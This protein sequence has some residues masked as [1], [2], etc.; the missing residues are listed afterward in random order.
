MSGET[1]NNIIGY[2][3]NPK[4]RHLS[5]GGSSGGEG[6]LIGL[7][8]SPVGFGSD[9]GGPIRVPAG[10]DGIFGIRPSNGRL[11]YRG[12]PISMDGQESIPCVIG[13]MAS[14][15]RS[16]TAIFRAV[17]DAKPWTGDPLVLDMP[18]RNE[19]ERFVLALRKAGT[20]EHKLSFGLFASD[21]IVRPAPPVRRAMKLLEEVIRA[22][23]HEYET[24]M[25]D[26]GKDIHSSLAL[27][28][29][30]IANQVSRAFGTKA[31]EEKSATHIAAI[32]VRLRQY[33]EYYH[34]YWNSTSKI[35]S[36]GRP[37]DAFIS[38]LAPFAAARPTLY[39]HNA[40]STTINVLDYSAVALPVTIVDKDTDKADTAY[41]PV[42]EKDAECHANCAVI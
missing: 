6:A 37:V 32:N 38:P 20:A 26:G 30:P 11:P 42:S 22:A 12:V 16:L 24:W 33:R 41:E 10:F 34:D 23:G 13:P 8:G 3:N 36:T 29:E 21:G 31:S 9:I 18:W 19:H 28:G 17:L 14:T 25:F 4:N 35:T 1:V 27:S 7:R 2:T 40:Y 5:A 39:N 15:I